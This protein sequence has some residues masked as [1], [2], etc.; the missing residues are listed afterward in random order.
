MTSQL[1]DLLL[2]GHS[3]EDYRQMF[4][5]TG[6]DLN[7]KVLDCA[8]GYAS[9]NAEM[10]ALGKLIV[11]CDKAYDL[12]LDELQVYV[13]TGLQNMLEKVRENREH[14]IWKKYPSIEA[15]AENHSEM[16]DKFLADFSQGKKQ[17]R[18]VSY[19]LPKLPFKDNQFNLALCAHLLFMTPE[20]D[21]QF[22][23]KS[24]LEMCRVAGEAR[25]FPLIDEAGE[26][27]PLLPPVMLSLQ[28]QN[29]GVEV[30]HVSYEFQKGANAMLR[31]WSQECE[32]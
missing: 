31:V 22:H 14:F 3:L 10:H 16:I 28:Q 18:Y 24:I 26:P 25:I 27:S 4:D 32:V 23:L 9:F 30:K 19:A 21:L 1:K 6:Q 8:S 20:L 12:S 15:L 7:K 5:L 17:G 11:S 2:W 13:D 29:Y